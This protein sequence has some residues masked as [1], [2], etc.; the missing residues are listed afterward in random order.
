MPRTARRV[1][2]VA[3]PLT[4]LVMAS[5]TAVATADPGTDRARRDL[6]AGPAV[7]IARRVEA[8]AELAALPEGIDRERALPVVLAALESPSPDLR[9]A[10]SGT[11]ARWRDRRALPALVDRLSHEADESTAAA[12][13][14]AIGAIGGP[15]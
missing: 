10:V 5:L 9:A 2:W 7:P 12:L 1:P 13:L 6:E 4:A 3:A 15:A 8:A 14:L 11:C